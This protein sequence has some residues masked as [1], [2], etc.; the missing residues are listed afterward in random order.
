MIFIYNYLERDNEKKFQISFKPL[1]LMP[2]K[3]S[4]L[5]KRWKRL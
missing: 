2:L 1:K 5:N 3:A 4:I